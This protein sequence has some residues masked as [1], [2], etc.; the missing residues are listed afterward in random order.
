MTTA[1]SDPRTRLAKLPKPVLWA[2]AS[3]FK[4]VS[5]S[6]VP[7]LAGSWI[8]AEAGIFRLD[9][10]L[11]A[12]LAAGAIQVGTN[13]W[14]DAADAASGVDRPDRLGPPRMTSL[15]L[16]DGA[17]VRRVALASFGVAVLAGLYLARIGGLPIVAIGMVSLALGYLYSMGPRPLSGL[18]FGEILVI[19]FFGVVAVSGTA[20]LHGAPP[21]EPETLLVGV[22]IG[23]P[24][25]A[26]LMLNNH[27]DRVQDARAGRRTLAI[28]IGPGASRLGYFAALLAA[29]GLGA[30]HAPSYW[31][32]PVAALSLWLGHAMWHWPVSS[33][34]NRLLAQ[35]ALFQGLLLAAMI[36]AT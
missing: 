17:E 15:G 29:V 27:R 31:L 33:R 9:A 30:I 23:L 22:M 8:A 7:V 21:L 10:M 19:L 28:V 3:R 18:P 16:L 11:V 2:I 5:L 20:L 32:L 24:A 12:M 1:V 26:V 35:T 6:Q 4:T 14:N 13:L 25:A 34:L 36:L